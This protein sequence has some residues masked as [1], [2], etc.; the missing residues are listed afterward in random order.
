VKTLKPRGYEK[1]FQSIKE[2]TA[3]AK[4]LRFS[5]IDFSDG[6][7]LP[8]KHLTMIIRSLNPSN[9]RTLKD[10]VRHFVHRRGNSNFMFSHRYTCT[11]E[12]INLNLHSTNQA[13]TWD[14]TIPIPLVTHFN[15]KPLSNLFAFSGWWGVS[16]DLVT[17]KLERVKYVNLVAESFRPPWPNLV[18]LIFIRFF[19]DFSFI[20]CLS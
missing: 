1:H 18:T 6:N 8:K 12:T 5:I 11:H 9:R 2:N 4:I 10:G 17:L 19:V 13:G 16:S 3:W 15:Q 14:P 20:S 7:A